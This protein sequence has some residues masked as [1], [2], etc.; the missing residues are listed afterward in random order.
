MHEVAYD[1]FLKEKGKSANK[2]ID[3]LKETLRNN[4]QIGIVDSINMNIK[5]FE[6]TKKKSEVAYFIA[7]EELPLSLFPKLLNLEKRHGVELGTACRNRKYAGKIIDYIS[8]KLADLKVALTNVLIFKVS[9]RCFYH[10]K[11]SHFYNSFLIFHP[12]KK[13]V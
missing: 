4:R 9:D 3:I 2:R 10:G 11:R 6:L 8:E 5:D 7:K 12:F 13:I 1:L